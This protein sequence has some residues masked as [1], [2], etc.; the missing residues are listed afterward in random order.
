LFFKTRSAITKIQAALVAVVIVVLAAGGGL[1][2]YTTTTSTT[3]TTTTT[4]TT[5]TSGTPIKIGFTLSLTG[6]YAYGGV[7]MLEGY[8]TWAKI[9]NDSGGIGGHPV[10]LVYYD[11]ESSTTLAPSLYTKLI[12]VDH[13]SFLFGPFSSPI[14][15]TVATVAAQ[16]GVP[17]LDA[18]GWSASIFTTGNQYVFLA[19]NVAAQ[20]V[21]IAY[22]NW[23]KSLPASQQAQLKT[24]AVA[25]A[26]DTVS[27]ALASGFEQD[28]NSLGMTMVYNDVFDPSATSLTSVFLALNAT[29]PDVVLL[30]SISDPSI[31]LAI[32][33][34]HELNVHPLVVFGLD[35]MGLS[36]LQT[37]LGPLMNNMMFDQVW[38]PAMTYNAPQ[39]SSEFNSVFRS[40]YGTYPDGAHA[41]VAFACG[42]ILQQAIA[43]T[44]GVPSNGVLNDAALRSYLASGATFNTI[45]GPIAF[46]PNGIPAHPSDILAQWQNGEMQFVYPPSAANATV[47]YPFQWETE[48]GT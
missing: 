34:M 5:T 45:Y 47:V 1:Y 28:A 35:T 2:Y 10:Q 30:S 16:N 31:E 20:N 36:A 21:S 14:T 39:S 33:T 18:L 40:A 43:A 48:P 44:G 32:E 24:Y 17:I 25:V 46:K 13:V 41:S 12:T 42:Q 9:V 7:P 3:S 29:H 37:A 19:S 27:T 4:T 26:S 15:A 11:D 6:D 38:S 22:T 23:I 8:E